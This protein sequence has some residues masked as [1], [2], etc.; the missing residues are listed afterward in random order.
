MKTVAGSFAIL[1]IIALGVFLFAGPNLE[2][3]VTTIQGQFVRVFWF[4]LLAQ[5]LVLPGLLVLMV[6]LALTIGSEEPTPELQTP[7]KL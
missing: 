7:V 4:G 6:A 5:L 2:E 1:V 3:V